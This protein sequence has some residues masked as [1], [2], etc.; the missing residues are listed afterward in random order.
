MDFDVLSDLNWLGVI[1]ATIVYFALGGLWYSPVFLG[2]P[3]MA[4]S[5]MTEPQEGE[6]PG[7]AL[8]LAPFISCFVASIATAMLATATGTDSAGEGIVLG[9]VIAIG[10]AATIAGVTGVFESTKPNPKTWVERPPSQ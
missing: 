4:A 2:K 8:Y 9:L 7:P 5:G 6:G 1:L 3:W 10:Y